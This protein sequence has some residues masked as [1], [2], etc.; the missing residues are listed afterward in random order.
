MVVGMDILTGSEMV[1]ATQTIS[2]ALAVSLG[3]FSA[4][5]SYPE[6][7]RAWYIRELFKVGSERIRKQG[8]PV[9]MLAS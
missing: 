5:A 7:R 4:V 6:H 9:S 3:P 1:A 8:L 2:A